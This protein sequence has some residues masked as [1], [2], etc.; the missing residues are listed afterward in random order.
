MPPS[1]HAAFPRH[2]KKESWGISKEEKNKTKQNK[3]NPATYDTKD[4]E[5]KNCT[6]TQSG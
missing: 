6:I 2:Q 4:V 3:K 1:W 5:T